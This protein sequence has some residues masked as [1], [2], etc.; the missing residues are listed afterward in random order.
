M[1]SNIFAIYKG[2]EYQAGMRADGSVIL[3]S[4]DEKDINDGFIN[5]TGINKSVKCYKYVLK[6]ELDEI[7]R[8]NIKAEYNGYEFS[9]IDQNDDMLLI[10]TMTGNYKVWLQ[11]GMESVDKGVYQK[12][13]DKK[14]LIIKI[15]KE[16]I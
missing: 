16:Y 2:K 11:R 1:K 8:K 15:E 6:S 5:N 10:S 3:R 14:H 12:W 7:Y 4:N 13:V 9:V